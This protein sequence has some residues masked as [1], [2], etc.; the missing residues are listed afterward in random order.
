[1]PSVLCVWALGGHP[2]GCR[3]PG[4]SLEGFSPCVLRLWQ[5]L[6]SH[7]R[8]LRL[9]SSPRWSWS[10]SV[11]MRSHSGTCHRGS[12]WRLMPSHLPPAR[13]RVASR[14]A[15]QSLG[16]RARRVLPAHCPLTR[17]PARACA[18]IGGR[19]MALPSVCRSSRTRMPG[20]SVC[21]LFPVGEHGVDACVDGGASVGPVCGHASEGFAVA[22]DGLL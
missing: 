18:H 12:P 15:G 2:P 7:R 6:L 3:R 11:P 19:V 16:S 20:R 21:C 10:Q 5:G 13:V 14:S 9:W 17:A 8:L 4:R 22:D 1:M